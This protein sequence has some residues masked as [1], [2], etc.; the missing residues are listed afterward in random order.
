V[1][2]LL[3]QLGRAIRVRAGRHSQRR[4]H[5][6]LGEIRAAFDT[7]ELGFGAGV[8]RNPF[9]LLGTGHRPEAEHEAVGH[10]GAEQGFG[11]PAITRAV[12]LGGRRGGMAGSPGKS[13]NAAGLFGGGVYW[14]DRVHWAAR[15][16]ESGMWVEN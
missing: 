8:E 3:Q 10:G 7:V 14:C 6:D 4:V 11:R 15:G 9:E 16:R 12:E 13:T 1:L 5:D 2:G